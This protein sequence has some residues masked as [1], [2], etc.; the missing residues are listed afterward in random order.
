MDINHGHSSA[1]R[2]T[3]IPVLLIAVLQGL[4]L[5]GL[6]R[7]VLAKHW[8][9]TDLVWLVPLYG[10]AL[11]LPLTAQL[12]AAHLRERLCWVLLAGVAAVIALAGWQAAVYEVVEDAP[13]A[14][15]LASLVKWSL[16]LGLLWCIA[17]PFMRLRL[18]Q[19]RW[20]PDYAALFSTTWR[21]LLG[22]IEAVVFTGLF[23]ILLMLWQTLFAMLGIDFFRELFQRAVFIYPVTAIVFGAAVYLVGNIDRLVD[24]ALVQVLGLLQW[25]LPLAALILVLFTLALLPRLSALLVNAQRPLSAALMLW[26]VVLTV[27]LLNAA[28]RDGRQTQTW[29]PWLRQGLRGV[30]L[31]LTVVAATA[32][33]ALSLRIADVGL[34]VSRYWGLVVALGAL[35]Y[36]VSYSVAAL[37]SGPWLAGIGTAN[38]VIALVLALVLALSVS[39]V[40]SPSRLAAAS[41]LA[42]A[43]AA[44]TAQALQGPLNALAHDL[45]GYGARALQGYIDSR[46]ADDPAGLRRLAL[47]QQQTVTRIVSTKALPPKAETF[48]DWLGSLK[49]RSGQL[50][51]PQSLQQAL[52]AD[53]E[54]AAKAENQ[55]QALPRQPVG[56]WAD[57]DGDGRQDLV[58]VPG[59]YDGI[60]VYRATA[61]GWQGDDLKRSIPA[62][63]LPSPAPQ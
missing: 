47:D 60:R 61:E 63:V 27:L 44:T 1:E 16:P 4:A 45:G 29:W 58:I 56:F 15:S 3:Q 9:A 21:T 41:Q 34:T 40:L 11:L 18:A 35:A 48:D 32:L 52:R 57:V 19:G 22:L 20:W 38:R 12:L 42:R 62:R 17:L 50:V 26:L 24:A 33:Y 10:L 49:A 53:F 25:L 14:T 5:Y 13:G 2:A 43:K 31:L 36:A 39:P 37:R 30:P 6:H 46:P 28:W 7:A 23:W 54:A 59:R 55:S 8:P 51:P